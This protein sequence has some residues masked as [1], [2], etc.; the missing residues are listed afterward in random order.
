[1]EFLERYLAC[2]V[3]ELMFNYPAD[4]ELFIM[5][6]AGEIIVSIGDPIPKLLILFRNIGRI[7]TEFI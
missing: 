2:T 1:L 4:K 5:G 6:R 7:Y 3:F